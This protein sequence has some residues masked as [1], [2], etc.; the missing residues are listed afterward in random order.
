MVQQF[1]D[2]IHRKTI[3]QTD[4]NRIYI[5]P[6]SVGVYYFSTAI[7]QLVMGVIFSNNLIL[8][9]GLI[10]L[11]FGILTAV[12]TNFH[13]ENIQLI[14][15]NFDSGHENNNLLFTL[16]TKWRDK[17]ES[18]P[19][20]MVYLTFKSNNKEFQLKHPLN[21]ELIIT[22]GEIPFPRGKY[23]LHHI[24]ISTRYPLNLFESWMNTSKFKKVLYIYPK[25][26]KKT[27]IP[28]QNIE[29]LGGKLEK[30][31]STEFDR[32]DKY[33]P[34]EPKNRI[35]WKVYARTEEYFKKVYEEQLDQRTRIILSKP[36]HEKKLSTISSLITL[37]YEQ[38]SYWEFESDDKF[39][40]MDQGKHHYV[41]CQNYLAT[42]VCDE[43][44]D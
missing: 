1:V 36:Y 33:Q 37:L 32:I 6:T 43:E 21:S 9:F 23:E 26:L 3:T 42:R 34:G 29:Y 22:R 28:E 27:S 20:V 16:H 44:S 19:G 40:P 31:V 4:K 10:L 2:Y 14:D 5:L 11:I 15:I 18:F 8:L 24:R 25:R 41:N 35:D 39:F 13:L 30:V 7:I 12:I 38:G 17:I